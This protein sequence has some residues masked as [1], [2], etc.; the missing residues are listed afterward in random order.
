MDEVFLESAEQRERQAR[1][2]AIARSARA[3]A[4]QYHPDF[5]GSTCVE[6][7]DPL[8]ATRLLM[9]RVRCVI[10]QTH[11]EKKHAYKS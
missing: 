11:I 3:L 10:C 2:D 7:A 5:D 1:D 6:C 9:G 4:P 8:P